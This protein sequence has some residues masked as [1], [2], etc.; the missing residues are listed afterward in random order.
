MAGS[1]VR[2]GADNINRDT[3]F[4]AMVK[5]RGLYHLERSNY[6]AIYNVFPGVCDRVFNL[7]G[8]KIIYRQSS[9]RR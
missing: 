2:V 1:F 7:Q 6:G 3:H 5:S 8:D 9:L 4:K